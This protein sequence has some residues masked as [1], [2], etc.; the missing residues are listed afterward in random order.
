LILF[1]F[2]M[3]PNAEWDELTAFLDTKLATL[4]KTTRI[5]QA[6]WVS[7]RNARALL[8]KLKAAEQPFLDAVEDALDTW[9]LSGLAKWPEMRPAV[10]GLARLRLE[11]AAIF[12]NLHSVGPKDNPSSAIPFPAMPDAE[13]IRWLT[14]EWWDQHGRQLACEVWTLSQWRSER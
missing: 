7:E 3:N 4:P 13:F 12:T 11:T 10:Q 1:N 8:Q 14:M 6:S 2:A 5:W 9:C